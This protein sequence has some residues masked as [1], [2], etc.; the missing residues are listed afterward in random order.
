MAAHPH[1]AC[2]ISES[3]SGRA[4]LEQALTVHEARG[5]RLSL[6]HAGPYLL[7]RETDGGEGAFRREDLYAD[8]RAWLERRAAEVPGAEAVLLAGPL[9]P[10]V[11]DWAL[12]AGADLIV[13]GSGSGRMPGLLP[14]APVHHLLLN[15]PCSVLVV[16]PP[17]DHAS[18]L[19]HIACCVDDPDAAAIVVG[20][21]RELRGA[22][23]RLSIVHVAPAD[24]GDERRGWLDAL[25]RDLPDAEAVVLGGVPGPEICDWADAAGADLLVAAPHDRTLRQRVALGSVTRHLVDRAPC[26]VLVARER[27]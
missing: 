11:C 14:G 4:A 17:G 5:G 27:A 25:V 18:P 10:A 1:V 21:A 2:C 15:A 3:P 8:A 24:A 7:A 6:L 20:Q 16:R 12:D 22:D 19:R 23:A 9:G 13:I 26:P